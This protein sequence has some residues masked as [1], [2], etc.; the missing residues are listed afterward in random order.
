[1]KNGG[2]SYNLLRPMMGIDC[3]GVPV[4]AKCIVEWYL[5]E[6]KEEP[7]PA[8]IDTPTT[9]GIDDWK[10]GDEVMHTRLGHGV[11][12]LVEEDGI[13]DVNFDNHGVKTMVSSHPAISKIKK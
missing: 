2:W 10:I 7:K 1:M 9:N 3:K 8:I 4:I 12:I 6:K 11:V 5:E 13:M